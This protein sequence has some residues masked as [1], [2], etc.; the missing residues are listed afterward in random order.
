MTIITRAS[1]NHGT[2]P[3]GVPISCVVLH[4]DASTNEEGTLSWLEAPKSGVSYH[5]LIGRDGTVYKIVPDSRRAWH[6]G[7]SEFHGVRNVNDF[8]IGV[9]FS[10]DQAGEPFKPAA[11]GAGV[12]LVADLCQRWSIAL[13]RITTHAVISPGRK[14]DPGPLF[15]L[16]KFVTDVGAELARRRAAPPLPPAA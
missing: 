16:A 1:P 7:I 12:Q 4:A 5:Y 2:R 8:S 15:N 6:A 10:N 3:I 11:L 13:T 9:S 14:H